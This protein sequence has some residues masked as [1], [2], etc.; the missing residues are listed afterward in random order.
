MPMVI[1]SSSLQTSNSLTLPVTSYHLRLQHGETSYSEPGDLRGFIIRMLVQAFMNLGP[2]IFSLL[3][4]CFALA[5]LIFFFEVRH[6]PAPHPIGFA[7]K[8]QIEGREISTL[9]NK[10]SYTTTVAWLDHG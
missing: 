2:M 6:Y 4:I 7:D 8:G 5:A 1:A 10:S 3:T 9:H